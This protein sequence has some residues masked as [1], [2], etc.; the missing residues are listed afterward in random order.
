MKRLLAIAVLVLAGCTLPSK[1]PRCDKKFIDKTPLEICEGIVRL[2][3]KLEQCRS[4]KVLRT[5]S[6]FS[7]GQPQRQCFTNGV[8]M[9]CKEKP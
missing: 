8:S 9:P 6:S 5:Q 4:E 1:E 7:P 3:N 2:Q